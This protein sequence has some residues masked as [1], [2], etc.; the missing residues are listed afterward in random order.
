MYITVKTCY[1]IQNLAIILSVH[2]NARTEPEFLSLRHGMVYPM[3]HPHERTIYSRNN[4]FKL[5]DIPHQ[6]FFKEDSE[7][8]R[9]T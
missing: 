7:D 3:H 6:S 5:N 1:D 9:K 2:M 4:I 8:I